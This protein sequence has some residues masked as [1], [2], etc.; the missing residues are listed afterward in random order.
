MGLAPLQTLMH[1]P[2]GFDVRIPWEVI[3]PVRVLFP[4]IDDGA[5]E[6]LGALFTDFCPTRKGVLQ[7]MEDTADARILFFLGGEIIVQLM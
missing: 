4:L 7:V 3:C 1:L 2:C 6:G 5:L